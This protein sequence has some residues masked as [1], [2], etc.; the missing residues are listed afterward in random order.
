MFSNMATAR[1]PSLAMPVQRNLTDSDGNHFGAF[2][3]SKSRSG[4]N[5]LQQLV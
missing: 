5:K 3:L 2:Q 4:Q 1:G